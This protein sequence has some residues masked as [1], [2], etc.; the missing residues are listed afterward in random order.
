MLKNQ[1]T[2]YFQSKV[3][4]SA[5]IIVITCIV[6]LPT[7]RN[8]L[9]N[10]D[11]RVYVNENNYIQ[12]LSWSNLEWIFTNSY[13]GNYHPLSML[14]LAADYH[15]GGLTP[16]M[17]HF[18]NLMFHAF[19]AV[20]VL[21]LIYAL[22]GKL[23]VSI[24]AG[25]LFGVHTLHVESVSWVSERK[26]VL[27]AFFYLFSLLLYLRFHK[28]RELKWYIL[29]VLLF[30]FSLLSKGQ[31]VSLAVTLLLI[32]FFQGRKLFTIKNLM[33]KV[34]F[35]LLAIIFGIIA[36]RSQQGVSATEM[37]QTEGQQRIFF[38]SYGFMMYM[39]KLVMPVF[40][41]A[42][43]PYPSLVKG[44]DLPLQFYLAPLAVLSF[45]IF[46]IISYKKSKPVFFSLGFFVINIFLVLQLLP[47]GGAIMAD[48]YA[49]IPSIGYC[50]LFGYMVLKKEYLPNIKVS[51]S[52][53]A[54]YI[55]LL[56]GMTFART[57]VWQNNFTLW[58]DVVEKNSEVHLAWYNLGNAHSDTA[59]YKGAIEKYDQA[60]RVF[61]LYFNAYINRANA[62]TKVND[63]VGA[64]EDL[65]FV[66]NRDSSIVNAY[67]NRAMA[68]RSL[69]DYNGS[70]ADYNKAVSMKPGQGE[71]Y[72]SRGSLLFDMKDNEGAI[73]DFTRAIEI[74]PKL[75]EAYSN[76]AFVKKAGGDLEGAAR[77]YSR[78]IEIAPENGELYSNR[79]NIRFQQGRNQEALADYGASLKVD[80]RNFLT[81]KN[82][83]AVFY[84][85][86]DYK[87][88]I[89]DYNDAIKLNPGLGELW[90][91]RAL[92]K[93]DAGDTQGAETDYK[94]AVEL[95]ANFGSEANSKSLGLKPVTSV[96]P[97]EQLNKDAMALDIQGKYQE[98]IDAFRKSVSLNPDYAEAWFNMG[99][100]YG[101]TGKFNDAVMVFNK[102][103]AINKNYAE[104]YAGLGIAYASLGKIDEALK[105]M[106]SAIKIN[107]QYAMVY[108]NR[109]LIYLN[110]GKKDLACTDLQKAVQL[111]YKEAYGIYQKECQEK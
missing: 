101:K 51:Y 31:A 20:L 104:A 24:V 88:A 84:S 64:I 30:L 78:A 95:D 43:Y 109:A 62:K 34:P 75:I 98:A 15:I 22:N 39:A 16:F 81:Y 73:K 71:L 33:E 87:S 94:K 90:Y 61:P 102:A 77:E 82:R 57:R 52:I 54:I 103:I 59:N 100:T 6:Y 38:S 74:N 67:I 47:V 26:D 105:N 72:I 7:L 111:G 91:T 13:M 49:Y 108:F 27:Y 85:M 1:K 58:T 12:N 99:N 8:N 10:W 106:A 107:P 48:R 44:A 45:I 37:V 93:K 41:S 68:R 96:A 83:G 28:K 21:L 9:T 60:I 55:L 50:Y 97:Y 65:N 86:K 79:G 46:L 36:I 29:S 92:L 53:A 17:F 35:F 14:S 11:D 5:I 80:P 70:L 42:Y 89:L 3:F 2:E 69:Q 19:N 56:G 23:N 40:L 18:T 63:Y 4:W 110:T 66:I 25:L 76:M 32:D